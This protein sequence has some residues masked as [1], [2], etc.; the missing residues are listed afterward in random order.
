MVFSNQ[1]VIIHIHHNYNIE[2]VLVEKLLENSG[3][4][5]ADFTEEGRALLSSLREDN[6]P[7]QVT[8]YWML[9]SHVFPCIRTQNT[10]NE[11]IMVITPWSAS[12]SRLDLDLSL[13]NYT[14]VPGAEGKGSSSLSAP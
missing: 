8:G 1:D 4:C 12:S 2:F 3:T 6:P 9:E 10:M 7:V 5:G 14:S 13:H 11:D